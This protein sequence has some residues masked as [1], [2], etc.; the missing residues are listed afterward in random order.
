MQPILVR[1]ELGTAVG[2]LPEIDP[3]MEEFRRKA[4]AAGVPVK[5]G[6]KVKEVLEQPEAWG[7]EPGT[8]GVVV[9]LGA[10][11][12]REGAVDTLSQVTVSAPAVISVKALT[13]EEVDKFHA[14]A[15]RITELRK[16][17]RRN[18]AAVTPGRHAASVAGTAPAGGAGPSQEPYEL[19]LG[20]PDEASKTPLNV[21]ELLR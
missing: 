20:T 10:M 21:L 9:F 15:R 18:A 8:E 7:A 6:L 13:A 17:Q 12:D 19:V 11:T 4:E 14:E 16:E 2:P 1:M 3:I 5:P